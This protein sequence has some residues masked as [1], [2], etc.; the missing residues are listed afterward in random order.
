MKRR[1][2]LARAGAIGLGAVFLGDI[3]CSFE[4]YG[5]RPQEIHTIDAGDAAEKICGIAHGSWTYDTID[6]EAIKRDISLFAEPRCDNGCAGFAN[7]VQLHLD[8]DLLQRDDPR[9]VPRIGWKQSREMDVIESNTPEIMDGK[10]R[11]LIDHAH[12][13]GLRVMLKP[14]LGLRIAHGHERTYEDRARINF[15]DDEQKWLE[16]FTNYTALMRRYARLAKEH[17]VEIFAYAC[18]LQ[19]TLHRTDEWRRVI[20]A[21]RNIGYDGKLIYAGLKLRKDRFGRAHLMDEEETWRTIELSDYICPHF[22]G[23]LGSGADWNVSRLRRDFRDFEA[24]MVDLSSRYGKPLLISETGMRPIRA[25]SADPWEFEEI[26]P[27]TPDEYTRIYDERMQ[28]R[29]IDS[30]VDRMLQIEV[31]KGVFWWDFQSDFTLRDRAGLGDL[32]RV[33]RPYAC[34]G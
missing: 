34:R 26:G 24:V 32:R 21:I 4:H 13:V 14:H 20:D 31:N 6:I 2:F 33:F 22:Y 19:G 16:F 15:S 12:D 11:E 1:D 9:I 18:E 30:V 10:I 3:C 28:Q 27:W 23:P 5:T 8:Y 17:D 7:F 25:H 29:W